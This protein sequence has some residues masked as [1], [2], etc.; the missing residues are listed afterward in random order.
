MGSYIKLVSLARDWR[1]VNAS[2][3]HTLM[4]E[5]KRKSNSST[6]AII[7]QTGSVDMQGYPMSSTYL[8]V[9][10]AR[11]TRLASKCQLIAALRHFS[12][13][14]IGGFSRRQKSPAS[15]RREFF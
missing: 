15:L 12:N 14:V 11:S 8:I 2:P 3:F 9:D 7:D 5:L 1:L 6:A 13:L 4:H 10:T